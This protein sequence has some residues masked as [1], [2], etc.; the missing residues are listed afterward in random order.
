MVEVPG[1][2][3]HGPLKT[4][5]P[6]L[7]PYQSVERDSLRQYVPGCAPAG[8]YTYVAYVGE[9]PSVKIDSSHF[10][11]AKTGSIPDGGR[12]WILTA[13][14]NEGG[15][16]ALPNEFALSQNFPN[17]FN[18]NTT[19]NYRLPLATEVR[20]E[21]INLLGQRLAILVDGRREAGN[22]S[23]IWETSGVASGVY[24]CKMTAGDSSQTRK[25]ILIR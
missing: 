7:S 10:Q 11:F 2:G 21:I 18:A 8:T 9:Y 19:I 14:F 20:L 25:M 15:S 23:V 17:P 16:W 1:L 22:W 6:L 24:Y 3:W 13:P 5:T 12:D 4:S